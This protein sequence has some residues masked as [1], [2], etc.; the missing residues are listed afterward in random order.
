MS[1]LSGYEL[2]RKLVDTAQTLFNKLY[3]VICD[4]PSLSIIENTAEDFGISSEKEFIT[5]GNLPFNTGATRIEQNN[6]YQLFEL[7]TGRSR[8]LAGYDHSQNMNE[9]TGDYRR[10][11]LANIATIVANYGSVEMTSYNDVI[12]MVEYLSTYI[13][14]VDQYIMY[15]IHYKAPPKEDMDAFK[16]L[17]TLLNKFLEKFNYRHPV[18]YNAI[19]GTPSM[20]ADL[21]IKK[22]S[23]EG[24]DPRSTSNPFRI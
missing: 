4:L 11:C 23:N 13:D 14:L 17:L 19:F 1:N 18:K 24:S 21:I 3:L 7:V 5:Y 16:G 15:D 9:G 8:D 20:G 6:D 2:H 12:E 22:D 10:L